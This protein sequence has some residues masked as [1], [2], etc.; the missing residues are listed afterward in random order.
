MNRNS[1]CSPE[2]MRTE[3]DG[4]KMEAGE[5]PARS[6]HCNEGAAV[7]RKVTVNRS[8]FTGRLAA[9]R[10]SESGNMH[11]ADYIHGVGE[12][13]VIFLFEKTAKTGCDTVVGEKTAMS[14]LFCTKY[15]GQAFRKE[16]RGKK[17]EQK[18]KV[19]KGDIHT[20]VSGNDNRYDACCG[21]GG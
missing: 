8:D 21:L 19:C 14:Q 7:Y 9:A 10:I 16:R 6:R 11:E 1:S 15:C 12:H 13:K 18:E 17:Y 5:S 4:A 3:P 2:G 20:A